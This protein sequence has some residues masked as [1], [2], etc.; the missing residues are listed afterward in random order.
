MQIDCNPELV[1]KDSQSV[2][3]FS[4]CNIIKVTSA[5]VRVHSLDTADWHIDKLTKY[6]TLFSLRPTMLTWTPWAGCFLQSNA[7]E[8]LT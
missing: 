5:C 8:L 2:I 4:E 1:V 3:Y 6:A 7:A